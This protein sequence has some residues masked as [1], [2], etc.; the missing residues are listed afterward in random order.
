MCNCLFKIE[1]GVL[2]QS[3]DNGCTWKTLGT[4]KGDTGATGPAGR[5]GVALTWQEDAAHCTNINDAYFDSNN[6]LQVLV[7]N[8]PTKVFIDYGSFQGPAGEDG[9]D[10][11]NG[12]NGINVVIQPSLAQCTEVGHCYI[13]YTVGTNYGHLMYCDSKDTSTSPYTYTFHSCGKIVG[14]DGAQG[15]EPVITV[16]NSTV[17]QHKVYVDSVLKA[18]IYDGITPT[19][20][21]VTKHW[22]IN[23]VDTGILAEGQ[24]GIQGI[25][26]ATPNITALAVVT[27][28]AGATRC[29]VTKTG[30]DENP[31]LTFTFYNIG[32]GGT[33]N[34]GHLDLKCK[35]TTVTQ[36]TANDSSDKTFNFLEGN[37][38]QLTGDN[39]GHT[40][41][42]D[43][44]DTSWVSYL[45]HTDVNPNNTRALVIKD[46]NS[47]II[48]YREDEI[49]QF[50]IMLNAKYNQNEADKSKS[51]QCELKIFA[52]CKKIDWLGLVKAN[53]LSSSQYT[54][55][56]DQQNIIQKGGIKLDNGDPGTQ[57]SAETYRVVHCNQLEKDIADPTCSLKNSWLTI[58]DTFELDTND[59]L[60]FTNSLGHLLT[61]TCIELHF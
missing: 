33:V 38:I 57:Y 52:Y 61:N 59:F 12:T 48:S 58:E 23:G 29:V 39:V 42:I 25:T 24:N 15:P 14:N 45:K 18:T 50:Y 13:D 35:G 21:S 54:T 3:S 17:G 7:Q 51:V 5:D 19:I 9:E 11:T 55:I 44:I 49:E 8:T 31:T 28:D 56:C 10:G 43:K 30:T 53:P 16:D 60:A 20:D 34:D 22:F 32:G 6:H 4:V 2:Y 27:T 47:N 36:F 40:I 26:G 37:D 46:K 1:N 41:T